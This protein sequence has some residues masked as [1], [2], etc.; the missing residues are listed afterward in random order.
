MLEHLL[1]IL[2]VFL[3]GG[4]LL[5]GLPQLQ[6]EVLRTRVRH[7]GWRPGSTPGGELR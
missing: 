4:I 2:A 5:G 6:Q 3:V 1:R 7:G